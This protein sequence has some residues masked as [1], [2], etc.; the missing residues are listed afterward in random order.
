[1]P[2]KVSN[3]KCYWVNQNPSCFWYPASTFFP[4]SVPRCSSHLAPRSVCCL[5]FALP[6][7]VAR[8]AMA[9]ASAAAFADSSRNHSPACKPNPVTNYIRSIPGLPNLLPPMRP[10]NKR[11]KRASK[12]KRDTRTAPPPPPTPSSSLGRA[13]TRTRTPP[14]P[15][16]RPCP[17]PP[18]RPG[19][20]ASRASSWGTPV[21]R[22]LGGAPRRVFCF[23]S[24]ICI[25]LHAARR[26]MA[27]A[28]PLPLMA[29]GGVFYITFSCL[30][31]ARAVIVRYPRLL[32]GDP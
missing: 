5:V 26:D 19:V 24:C 14:R 9:A 4:S 31:R 3:S 6:L 32:P 20:S 10:P 7:H 25:P 15:P 11:K 17:P 28:L 21:L 29:N 16:S 23:E 1:M 27:A 12:K 18:G 22:S 30:G 13:R 2:Q 8:R